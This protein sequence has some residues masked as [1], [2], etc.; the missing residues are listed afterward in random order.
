MISL[1]RQT[2]NQTLACDLT[3]ASRT[4]KAKTPQQMNSR[5]NLSDDCCYH[6]NLKC[7][8]IILSES[9]MRCFPGFGVPELDNAEAISN[10]QRIL[11]REI[12]FLDIA[13]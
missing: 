13:I 1:I 2:S 4:V 7:L 5:E 11:N 9:K 6:N 3:P 12:H 10:K 8:T